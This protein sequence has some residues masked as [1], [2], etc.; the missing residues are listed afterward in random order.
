MLCLPEN[1]ALFTLYV[2]IRCNAL[3]GQNYCKLT[4]LGMNVATQCDRKGIQIRQL[5]T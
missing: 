1:A 4:M 3:R 2:C 5:V